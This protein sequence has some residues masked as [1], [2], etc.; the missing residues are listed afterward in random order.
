MNDF[1]KY[2]NSKFG[3][4]EVLPN[5]TYYVK[6]AGNHY[7]FSSDCTEGDVNLMVCYPGVGGLDNPN[8]TNP[9]A[10]FHHQVKATGVP[11]GNVIIISASTFPD[12]Y[13]DNL[14]V[15]DEVC[16]NTGI[17]VSSAQFQGFSGSGG[18]VVV[19]T[20]RYLI[21]HPE[22]VDN[23][24]II[25][26]DGY[27]FNDVMG[28]DSDA[29]IFVRDN[30][31]PIY[32]VTPPHESY[33]NRVK[34]LNANFTDAGFNSH[35]V[36]LEE[37]DFCIGNDQ[38]A[39]VVLNDNFCRYIGGVSDELGSL[40]GYTVIDYKNGELVE[41]NI[42]DVRGGGSSYIGIDDIK[43]VL[44]ENEFTFQEVPNEI[45][46]KYSGLLSLGAFDISYSGDSSKVSSS[47]EYIEGFSNS[48][49]GSLKEDTL[50]SSLSLS[51]SG[52]CGPLIE[53][54]NKCLNLYYDTV[55]E[56]IN[57]LT[58]ETESIISIGQSIADMDMYLKGNVPTD[59]VEEEINLEEE[60]IPEEG[61]NPEEEIIPEENEIVTEEGAILN[62]NEIDQYKNDFVVDN[63]VIVEEGLI[64]SDD[65][66]Y[67]SDYFKKDNFV[68]PKI[69][70]EVMSNEVVY[71]KN[72]YNL[73]FE[74]L[75]EDIV[76]IK[77]QY[78]FTSLDEAM[79]N[80]N[81]LVDKYKNI[82]GI[83][84]IVLNGNKINIIFNMDMYDNMSYEE[85]LS[86][87]GV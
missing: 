75:N 55:S 11:S 83:K 45:K 24:A 67:N 69:D 33:S 42:D 87:F 60:I 3:G 61:I 34:A 46:L 65:I 23:T 81:L 18:T 71:E 32:M 39:A 35:L 53:P 84:D 82:D 58:L 79:N 76:S 5:G 66:P 86:E 43:D 62:E 59:V 9:T 40:A 14:S 22:L 36:V 8:G 44:D 2:L 68:P 73:V 15:F 64:N 77:Y 1:G 50:F 25:D 6:N 30:K 17:D 31:V 57:K 63:G 28:K 51:V 29:S 70:N 12:G 7:Y 13:V 21:K 48:I 10:N 27:L 47:I 78:E 20:G 19:E 41:V 4:Y 54:I 38:A 85:I 26:V 56:L 52:G 49:I 37:K 72:G 80:Y 16:E 74:V